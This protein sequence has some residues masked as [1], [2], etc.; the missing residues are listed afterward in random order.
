[1]A[2][3]QEKMRL[4]EAQAAVLGAL[5]QPMRLAIVDFLKDGEQCVCDI[6]AYLGAERSNVSKHLS[7]MQKAGIISGEKR[8]L[9]AMY[10]LQTPCVV[11]CLSCINRVIQTT[12]AQQTALGELI[13]N[14]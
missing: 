10:R 14:L 11:N 9:K 8:G 5:A 1:M 2:A 12:L 7:V 4:Y 13:E 3:A 6:A